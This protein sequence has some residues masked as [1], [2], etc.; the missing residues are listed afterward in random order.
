MKRG[1]LIDRPRSVATDAD[2]RLARH[3]ATA[4]RQM[5]ARDEMGRITAVLPSPLAAWEEPKRQ[6]GQLPRRGGK[7]KKT[8]STRLPI[9]AY[10]ALKMLA[11]RR[12]VTLSYLVHEA[13]ASVLE[14]V[15]QASSRGLADHPDLI[16]PPQRLHRRGPPTRPQQN[17]GRGGFLTDH[18]PRPSY[19]PDFPESGPPA[20]DP[21]RPTGSSQTKSGR[22]LTDR[23]PRR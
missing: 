11:E 19:A 6:V 9:G 8:I 17:R 20:L 2:E 5:Q 12:E 16:G 13:L 21:D 23:W 7:R 14:P 1:Y 18:M 15:L 4:Q 3:L 22:L 10:V